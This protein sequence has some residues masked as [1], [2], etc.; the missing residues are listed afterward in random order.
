M[1]VEENEKEGKMFP[2]SV[3]YVLDREKQLNRILRF[4]YRGQLINAV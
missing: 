4:H 2:S 1:W 3:S